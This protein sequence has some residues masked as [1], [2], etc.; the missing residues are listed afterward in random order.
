MAKKKSQETKE[1]VKEIKKNTKK[2]IV[3]EKKIVKTKKRGVKYQKASKL[4]D[5]NK[6]YSIKESIELLK[7]AKFAKFDESFE[8]HLNLRD[9]Q[10]KGEVVLP[11]GTG[12]QIKAVI[13][14]DKL[15]EEIE[16][17]IINFD[18]LIAHPSFMPKLV[19]L[20]KVLGPKGL[21]PNPKNGT[22]T[23][24]PEKAVEKFKTGTLRYKSES[25]FPILHQIVGRVSF[26]EEQ[27]LANIIALLKAVSKNKIE[28]AF[29]TITMGPSVK[30]NLEE[31]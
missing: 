6:T 28:S 22:L 2:E 26:T 14:D 17:G 7:K 13:L 12:K 5:K 19:K 4:I 16:K 8:L 9:S 29:I 10:L 24:E 23:P 18:I 15:L 25:K 11:F 1:E 27:L 21:M 3:E 31:I 30:L 20:A